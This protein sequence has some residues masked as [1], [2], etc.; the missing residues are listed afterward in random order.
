MLS[1][2]RLTRVDNGTY[3][4]RGVSLTLSMASTALGRQRLPARF[5]VLSY[6]THP[7]KSSEGL[8]IFVPAKQVARQ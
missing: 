4:G 3:F 8:L 5:A 7:T 1:T 2:A 6:L